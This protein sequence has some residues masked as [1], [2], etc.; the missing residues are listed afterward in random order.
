MPRHITVPVFCCALLAFSAAH[1][2]TLDYDAY[3]GDRKVGEANV[4]IEKDQS[5]YRVSGKA[6]A[7]GIT[8]F[9]TRWRSYFIVRG[10]FARGHD[11]RADAFRLSERKSSKSKDI[12]LE[13]GQVH[14][15]KDGV[16]TRT[17]APPMSRDLLTALFAAPDCTRDDAVHN[18]KD[19]WRL[20]LLDSGNN[21]DGS[22]YCTFHVVDEDDKDFETRV[23]FDSVDGDVVPVKLSF[24]GSFEG[25]L[26]LKRLATR[27]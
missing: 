17:T 23:S 7:I 18:G 15:V 8:G 21:D 12:Y 6:S 14:L 16:P 22:Q 25:R 26:E 3:L 11:A 2:T 9:L 13:D 24:H 20:Q 27:G 10:I 5:G 4:R 19:I 1:A